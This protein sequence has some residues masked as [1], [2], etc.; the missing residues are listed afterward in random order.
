MAYS[1]GGLI[2]ASDYN[3]L[4][5]GATA[6]VSG[7]LNTILATG[8]G[9]AG[10]GQSS[11]SNVSVAGSVTAT[12]W[13][14]LVGSVNLVSKHQNSGYSNLSLY[15]AG[16]TINATNNISGA[17][18]T[19]YTNRAVKA[20][21]GTVVTG[22]VST[23]N[24][25]IPNQTAAAS[26]T[27]SKTATFASANQA[28]YF[29]NAGGELRFY[30]TGYNNI[31]GTTRGQAFGS[32]ASSGFAGKT[33]AGT[34]SSARY[35]SGATLTTDLTG[36]AGYYRQTSSQLTLT[37]IDG[38]TYGAQYSGDQLLFK[39]NTNGAQGSN[40]DAGTIVKLE[41][42]VTSGS[43]SPAIADSINCDIS[44]RLD[45]AYPSTTFLSNTWGAVTI[46]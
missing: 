24:L 33:F 43:Q 12:Q 32:L 26:L 45:V 38:S 14:T 3:L 36:N 17:L 4:V 44:Y 46:S 35:G 41:V 2:E 6:N 8:Y 13:S 9:N 7:Q 20:A 31:G 37:Q 42:T 39:S 15:S 29:F 19:A 22:S 27:F 5:G 11:V 34:N 18:T 28:R 25:T 30:V 1:S 40:G 23:N 16:T 21:T 10:Y